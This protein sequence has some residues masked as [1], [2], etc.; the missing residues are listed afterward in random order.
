MVEVERVA[1]EEMPHHELVD[2]L[3]V[4]AVQVLEFVRRGEPLD[5]QPVGQ[6]HIGLAAEQFLRFERGDFADGREDRRRVGR[7]PLDR[8]AADRSGTSPPRSS[9][10]MKGRWS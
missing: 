6:D 5:V 4:L 2:P 1:G 8:E 9:A 7:R 10:L 3:L